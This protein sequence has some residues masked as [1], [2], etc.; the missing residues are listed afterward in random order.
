MGT[1]NLRNI[2]DDIYI[3]VYRLVLLLGTFWL[4]RA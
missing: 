3:V 1:S 2:V 4:A